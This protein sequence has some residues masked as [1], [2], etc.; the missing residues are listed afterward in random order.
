MFRLVS[1]GIGY[2]FGCIQTAYFLGKIANNIDIR[3]FGSGNAGT[4]NVIRVLGWKAGV[5]TFLGDLLKAVIAV[6][7]CRALFPDMSL[8]ASLYAGIG[9][10]MGHNWPFF[11]KFKGGK[12]IAATIGTILAVDLTI[13]LIVAAILVVTL[14]ITR[15]VSLGA[16]LL[17]ASIPILFAIFYN[18]YANYFEIIGL[19]LLITIFAFIRHR[20]NIKRLL[21]GTESKLGQRSRKKVGD[22]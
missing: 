12:G 4:T 9:V 20:A 18:G 16:L 17:T 15:Y 5:I 8:L 19:G 2:L 1:I 6:F 3:N 13:G 21:S 14:L 22:E 11:L 7:V 10:I